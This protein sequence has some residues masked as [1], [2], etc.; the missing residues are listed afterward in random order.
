MNKEDTIVIV[1]L[2]LAVILIIY[3]IW[4]KV[5]TKKYDREMHR[6]NRQ[7]ELSKDITRLKD[8]AESVDNPHI[9]GIIEAE[10]ASSIKVL[11]E[12]RNRGKK[13]RKK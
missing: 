1:I 9:K 4:N 6:I 13:K 8:A 7:L 11:E 10:I 2:S 5:R 12:V 3:F